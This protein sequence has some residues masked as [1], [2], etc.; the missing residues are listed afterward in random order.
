MLFGVGESPSL[1]EKV[2]VHQ[3]GQ[4]SNDRSEV[5]VQ[6]KRNQSAVNRVCDGCVDDPDNSE[7]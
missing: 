3:T 5:I 6:P 1:I 4:I 2:A 7:S